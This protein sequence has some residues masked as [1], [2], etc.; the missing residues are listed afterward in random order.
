MKLSTGILLLA[1]ALVL[2]RIAMA[3]PAANAPAPDASTIII[4]DS[5]FSMHEKIKG[6]AKIDI[7]KRAVRELVESLPA[8]VRLG[9]VAYGHLHAPSTDGRDRARMRA[10]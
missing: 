3:A 8:D 10:R 6:E 9:L 5:S 7:A 1:A 4:L 2:P